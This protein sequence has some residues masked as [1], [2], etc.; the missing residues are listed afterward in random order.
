MEVSA[1]FWFSSVARRYVAG[2]VAEGIGLDDRLAVRAVLADLH[3]LAGV[4][5]PAWL[6]APLDGLAVHPAL[7]AEDDA[8]ALVAG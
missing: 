3:V 2:L 6:A 4:P 7:L 1:L 5:V 8:A